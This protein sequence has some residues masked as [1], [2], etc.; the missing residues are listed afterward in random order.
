MKQPF[1]V[2]TLVDMQQTHDVN[3]QIHEGLLKRGE[4]ENR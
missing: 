4:G 2:E 1:S 3:I